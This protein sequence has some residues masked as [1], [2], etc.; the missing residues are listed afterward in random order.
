MNKTSKNT[1]VCIAFCKCNIKRKK[2]KKL[3]NSFSNSKTFVN[4]SIGQ[5]H[6]ASVDLDIVGIPE[7]SSMDYSGICS[8][9]P[10]LRARWVVSVTER[11]AK[12]KVLFRSFVNIF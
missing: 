9:T 7:K 2:Q 8:S 10:V 1:S 11:V 6:R 4:S 12:A 3:Q 5:L